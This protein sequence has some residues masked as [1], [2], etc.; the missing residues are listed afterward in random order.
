MT[1]KKLLHWG[2]EMNKFGLTRGF[3]V[4]VMSLMAYSFSSNVVGIFLQ[5]FI[6]L[7]GRLLIF[8]LGFMFSA[9]A[10]VWFERRLLFSCTSSFWPVVVSVL[11]AGIILKRADSSI[12]DLFTPTDLIGGITRAADGLIPF[13][14]ANFPDIYANYHAH[15]IIASSILKNLLGTSTLH[16][17][18]LCY[19]IGAASLDLPGFSG[20]V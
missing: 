8:F 3:F 5:G 18:L 14:F 20:P 19:A 10:L 15:F 16:S 11:F 13:S 7:W 12:Y 1:P 2:L 17:L 4:M 6:P 9:V